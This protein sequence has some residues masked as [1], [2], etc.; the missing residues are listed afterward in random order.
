[1]P[2][3]KQR[4]ISSR[5]DQQPFMVN[6]E[7]E[8]EE[9]MED[10]IN[11]NEVISSTEESSSS[12]SSDYSNSLETNSTDACSPSPPSTTSTSTSSSSSSSPPSFISIPSTAIKSDDIIPAI[13]IISPTPTEPKEV[14]RTGLGAGA[15]PRF[16]F[17]SNKSADQPKPKSLFEVREKLLPIYVCVCVCVIMGF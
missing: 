3:K 8:V 2:P 9:E 17:P 12:S 14:L 16:A 4:S 10:D 13:S 15:A 5:S 6:L 7:M 11:N 1:M